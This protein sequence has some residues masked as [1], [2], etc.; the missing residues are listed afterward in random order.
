MQIGIFRGK[1]YSFA[2]KRCKTE[3]KSRSSITEICPFV[4][5]SCRFLTKWTKSRPDHHCGNSIMI[6]FNKFYHSSGSLSSIGFVA[7]VTFMI[8]STQNKPSEK[9]FLRS[10]QFSGSTEHISPSERISNKW[11]STFWTFTDIAVIQNLKFFGNALVT[12]SWYVFL[13]S[14]KVS[15]K[16]HCLLFT[17]TCKDSIIS[18]S[19]KAWR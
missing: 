15:T 14:K 3:Q 7:C 13:T 16:S 10:I 19:Y 12:Q 5:A 1:L 8:L 4:R 2:N 11:F 17:P 6:L 18:D 9:G